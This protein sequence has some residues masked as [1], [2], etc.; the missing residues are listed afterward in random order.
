MRWN[1]RVPPPGKHDAGYICRHCVAGAGVKA[2]L[3]ITPVSQFQKNFNAQLA[4]A[5][6]G[7]LN[8]AVRT[9]VRVAR[10]HRD[11]D[12]Q[13]IFFIRFDRMMTLGMIMVGL[14]AFVRDG[15][16]RLDKPQKEK[17][18]RRLRSV[19]FKIE[20]LIKILNESPHLLLL[21]ENELFKFWKVML[22][23]RFVERVLAEK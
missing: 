5:L 21:T 15:R 17:L 23:D 3:G 8:Q 9:A 12:G 19:R 7:W 13:E 4:E 22:G 11:E 16:Y 1:L 20:K 6:E 18:L 2:V 10:K 14:R